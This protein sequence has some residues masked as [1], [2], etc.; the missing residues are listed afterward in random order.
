M[1]SHWIQGLSQETRREFLHT[2]QHNYTSGLLDVQKEVLS[3]AAFKGLPENIRTSQLR[4]LGI[5][6]LNDPGNKETSLWL[7]EEA[8]SV[9]PGDFKTQ[10]LLSAFR[11]YPPVVKGLIRTWHFFHHTGKRLAQIGK[12]IPKE[13]PSSLRPVGE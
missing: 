3:S 11:I 6:Y 7:L 12:R 8:L 5:A 13:A 1:N 9:S 2:L 4:Q 10:I